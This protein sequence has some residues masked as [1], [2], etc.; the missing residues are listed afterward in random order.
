M[1]WLELSVQ[2]NTQGTDA[3]S[4]ILMQSGCQGVMIQDRADLPCS[5]SSD[6]WELYDSSLSDRMPEN[7]TVTGWLKKDVEFKCRL[8]ALKDRLAGMQSMSLSMGALE[9]CV[10]E[11]QD[12]DWAENW[13]V[14]YKPFH[15]CKKIV[16]VP[17]WETYLQQDGEKILRIDPGMAFGTGQHESTAMC[18]VLLEAYIKR[19]QR[20]LDIGTGSGILAIGA[21]LMGASH[22]YASDID[23]EAVKVAMQNVIINDMQHIISVSEGSLPDV[24][25]GTYNVC[26]ANIVSDVICV[27]AEPLSKMLA[28]NGLFI[29][30]GILLERENDVLR[31]LDI[32]GYKVIKTLRNGE[33]AAFAAT[34]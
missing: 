26:V 17:S 6:G 5:S 20:V 10:R 33:W 28:P 3:V 15:I 14:Y 24:D 16:I 25:H 13:K 1:T 34:R 2:T 29:C 30:S 21:A 4:E 11:T 31:V 18:M 32:N 9:L 27:L 23:P 7:A 8:A 19:G 22:V 12:E